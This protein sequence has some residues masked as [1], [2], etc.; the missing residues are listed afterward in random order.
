MHSKEPEH[1]KN[2]CQPDAGG[3]GDNQDWHA[4]L[5]ALTRA[6]GGP[7]GQTLEERDDEGENPHRSQRPE[8]NQGESPERL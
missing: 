3:A 8:P 4:G 1:E 2:D 6:A 7:S 5:H